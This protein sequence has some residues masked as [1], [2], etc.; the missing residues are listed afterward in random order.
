MINRRAEM[1]NKNPITLDIIDKKRAKYLIILSALII[2]SALNIGWNYYDIMWWISWYKIVETNGISSIFSIYRLCQLPTCKAPYLPLAILIFLP[3]YAITTLLPVPFRFIVLKIILVLIPAIAI[4]NIL[5]K[6]RDSIIALLWFLSLPFIQILFVLQFDVIISLLVL[7]ATYFFSNQKYHLSAITLALSSLIKHVTVILLPIYL[8]TLLIDKKYRTV[9]K[10]LL[11]YIL[12]V[13]TIV[14][15]FFIND[16]ISMIEEVILFHGARAPQDLSIWAILTVVLETNIVKSL[17]YIDNIWLIPFTIGYISLIIYYIQIHKYRNSNKDYRHLCL[18]ISLALLM[19]ITFNK[20][21]N[22]N[23]LVWIVPTALMA[24]SGK[25]LISFYRLTA[26]IVLFGSIPYALM[27]TF[28]PASIDIPTLLAEDLSYWN[29]RALLAQSL[30]YYIFYVSVMVDI[31][32]IYLSNI[33]TPLEFVDYF[34]SAALSI[35]KYKELIMIIIIINTQ[36]MLTLLIIQLLKY[37][38]D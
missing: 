29:A 32:S 13:L 35:Y 15:P 27:L 10:Y 17:G 1:M 34:Y 33:L 12:V 19:F 11:I 20:I 5:K 14:L 28:F 25:D 36:I 37:L 6:N 31:L 23:Y 22:L 3:S 24:L 38:K 7:L 30:N 18:C 16:P 21:G 26:F 2:I 8:I 4:Y 9:L